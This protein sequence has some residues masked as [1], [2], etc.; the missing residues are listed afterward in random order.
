M[1]GDE[2]FVRSAAN[3][4]QRRRLTG[5]SEATMTP[6][7]ERIH[8]L[9]DQL[10]EAELPAVESLLVERRAATDPFLQ[11]LA[12]APEDD[13]P[14]TDEDDAAIQEGLDAIARGDVISDAELRRRL[15][16]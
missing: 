15:G 11:A 10:P 12:N 3:P 5:T 1:S 9:V 2:D 13:E 4:D 7:R 16:L 6:V 8:R 14:L